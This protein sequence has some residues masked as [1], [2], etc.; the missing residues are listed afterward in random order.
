M[1]NSSRRFLSSVT[2]TT[3][4]ATV[5]VVAFLVT[6]AVL[7]ACFAILTA[8]FMGPVDRGVIVLTTTSASILMLVG[9]V[10]AATGGR[11]LLS[12]NDAR[13][14]LSRHKRFTLLLCSVHLATMALLGWP[15]LLLASAWRGWVV[16]AAFLAYGVAT[17]G[18]Y[19][20]REALHGVGKHVLATS[21][22]V[23]L[24]IALVL[25]VTLLHSRNYV[26]VPS[27]TW[28]LALAA[29]IELLFLAISL[30]VVKQVPGQVVPIPFRAFLRLS[31]PALA[32][33][34]AQAFTIRGDRI[35]LGALDGPRSVGIY[36]TAATFTE[37]LWIIPLGVGQILF[38]LSG[39]GDL[40]RVRQLRRI[41]L[42]SV[43]LLAVCGA[44][45]AKPAVRIL[46]GTE[47]AASVPLIW[48]LLFASI[49][50]SLYLLQAQILN[51]SGDLRGTAIAGVTSAVVLLVGCVSFIPLWGA[52]GAACASIL[53]YSSMAAIASLRVRRITLSESTV[54][55]GPNSGGPSDV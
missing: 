36:G 45:T 29:L 34:L 13:Y 12:R 28:L 4:G 19:M 21:G 53:A 6:Q 33:A 11:M 30:T 37:A 55:N 35:L 1:R 39:Q 2:G 18:V 10:G 41:A 48:V 44:G 42:V 43:L 22:D 31:A 40:P 14:S 24:N 7:A 54:L 49:P 17:L 16:A 20:L 46:L 27:V 50:M 32:G 52:V 26:R 47:Y 9:S 25:G 23:V 8:R 15:L 5:P 3:L 38:R 51:G